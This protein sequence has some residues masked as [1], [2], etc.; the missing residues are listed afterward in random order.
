[1]M[2]T[3]TRYLLQRAASEAIRA[4]QSLSPAASAIHDRLCVLYTQRALALIVIEQRG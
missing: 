1:M 4:I 3:E 2:M